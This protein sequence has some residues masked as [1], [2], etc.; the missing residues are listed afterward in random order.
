M[1][2]GLYILFWWFKVN[3][4]VSTSAQTCSILHYFDLYYYFLI[5]Q[6]TVGSDYFQLKWKETFHF[7]FFFFFFCLTAS[8][9]K[10]MSFFLGSPSSTSSKT[11]R[12]KG[13]KKQRYPFL[14]RHRATRLAVFWVGVWL[15]F[16]WVEKIQLSGSYYLY[17]YCCLYPHIQY[18]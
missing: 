16:S 11:W 2:D 17:C 13:K 3:I 15:I 18:T 9:L 4:G 7:K 14:H 6:V 8:E 12:N 10:C 5:L 1:C